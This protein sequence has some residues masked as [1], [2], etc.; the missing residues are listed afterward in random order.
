MAFGC[1]VGAILSGIVAGVLAYGI[2]SVG[3]WWAWFLLGFVFGI[4]MVALATEVV[5]SAVVC[6]FVCL[7][8]DPAVLQQTK[9][10]IYNDL[11]PA[12]TPLSPFLSLTAT[13]T[14]PYFI[15]ESSLIIICLDRC[16]PCLNG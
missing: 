15:C 8:E 3:P 6:L 7:C 1:V 16:A 11:V 12:V 4:F 9:P 10:D 13:P 14:A 5:E 2:G